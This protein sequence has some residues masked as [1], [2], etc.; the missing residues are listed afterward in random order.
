MDTTAALYAWLSASAAARYVHKVARNVSVDRAGYLSMAASGALGYF[1]TLVSGLHLGAALTMEVV[2]FLVVA[3]A[4]DN[5]DRRI[6]DRRGRVQWW[7]RWCSLVSS[8]IKAFIGYV[9]LVS[10]LA[11]SAA[12][13]RFLASSDDQEDELPSPLRQIKPVILRHGPTAASRELL[14][15]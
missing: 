6:G 9:G 4:R 11:G 2:L 15:A 3:A 1:G 7:Q 10:A 5:V 14:A 13:P 8:F 12:A